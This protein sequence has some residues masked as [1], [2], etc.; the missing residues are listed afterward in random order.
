MSSP[1]GP[2]ITTDL[3]ELRLISPRSAHQ[4]LRLA[5]DPEL[6]RYLQWPAHGSIDD[7][8]GFISDARALWES[9]AAFLPG[10]HDRASDQLIGSIGISSI[11]RANRR[12]EVGT[13][14]GVPFQR[15]GY[16]RHAKAAIFWYAFREVG[17]ERLEFI[18]RSD[19]LGSVASMTGMPGIQHEGTLRRRLLSATGSHDAEIFSLLRDDWNPDDWPQVTVTHAPGWRTRHASSSPQE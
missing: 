12:A 17:L 1:L 5:Q 10:I 13:W 4:L 2:H 14:I 16:N 3:I 11:D 19:N 6:T 15:S 9:E 7:S 8:L 18:V